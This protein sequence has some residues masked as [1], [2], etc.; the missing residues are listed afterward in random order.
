MAMTKEGMAA[1]IQLRLDALDHTQ[2]TSATT[3][4]GYQNNMLLALCQGIIDHMAAAARVYTTSGAP[5][6]EHEGKI[7]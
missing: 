4:Q 6:S 3:A 5:D 1:A 7:E 2:T